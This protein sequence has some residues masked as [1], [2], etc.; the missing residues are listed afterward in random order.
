MGQDIHCWMEYK[1]EGHP[2]RI[3]K[4]FRCYTCGG[5]GT[6]VNR[7]AGPDNNYEEI[8]ETCWRCDGVGRDRIQEENDD[9]ETPPYLTGG[10]C[11]QGRNYALF[12]ALA[13][14]GRRSKP[15]L[16]D[17][18]GVPKDASL[19]FH[20][21]MA[22]YG[23]DAHTCSWLNLDDIA[24]ILIYELDDPYSVNREALAALPYEGS[25]TRHH[26]DGFIAQT[27]SVMQRIAV[28]RGPQNVRIVFFFDN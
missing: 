17:E 4:Q 28:K 21:L 22:G 15:S 3:I 12:G 14:S 9:G 11:Y 23:G 26:M 10:G 27:V 7:I 20:R 8:E 6:V 25:W 19:E 16:I 2:W 1:R 5:A 24:A 18:R 13:P